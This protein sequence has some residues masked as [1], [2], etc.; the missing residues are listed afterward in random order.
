L[1]DSV[2][3]NHQRIVQSQLETEPSLP[4]CDGDCWV[5]LPNYLERDWAEIIDCW[6]GLTDILKE[7][8]ER[9]LQ[10]SLLQ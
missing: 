5:A 1:V 6:R 8:L 7:R 2:C 3:N 10:R 9:L 4:G